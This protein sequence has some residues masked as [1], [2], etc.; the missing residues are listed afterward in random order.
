MNPADMSA[1]TKAVRSTLSVWQRK[2]TDEDLQVWFRAL[3]DYPVIKVQDA[4]DAHAKYGKFAPKPADI[5]GRINGTNDRGEVNE[6]GKYHR[7]AK[8]DAPGC[9]NPPQAFEPALCHAHIRQAQDK[10]E[11]IT[12]EVLAG[13]IAFPP[14]NTEKHRA[15]FLVETGRYEELKS[16]MR[17]EVVEWARGEVKA[18]RIKLDGFISTSAARAEVE[19]WLGVAKRDRGY[20][21]ASVTE[22]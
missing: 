2:A 22:G 12:S 10:W 5:L 11:S 18:K 20:Q 15:E 3:A 1:L 8:C 6:G 13:N 9:Q 21:P 4:F 7:P 17:P 19:K 16:T 14:T